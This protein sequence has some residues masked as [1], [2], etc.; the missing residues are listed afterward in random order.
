MQATAPITWDG[1]II[2]VDRLPTCWPVRPGAK[3]TGKMPGPE[4]QG[5]LVPLVYAGLGMNWRRTILLRLL[6]FKEALVA[7]PYS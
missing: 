7:I 3:H 5:M 4:R 1:Y 6:A 2:Y